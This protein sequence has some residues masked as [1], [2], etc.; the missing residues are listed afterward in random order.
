MSQS[1]LKNT[2]PESGFCQLCL[3]QGVKTKMLKYSSSKWWIE[4][5]K[6]A[7]SAVP[8][9]ACSILIGPGFL[10][11]YPNIYGDITLCGGCDGDLKKRKIL[12]LSELNT[13]KVK[14][15]VWEKGRPVETFV[16]PPKWFKHV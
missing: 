7:H 13:A 11:Q 1:K 15:L 8:C 10:E 12:Y 2:D 9:R 4:H 14:A 6:E 3:A 5:L 16:P